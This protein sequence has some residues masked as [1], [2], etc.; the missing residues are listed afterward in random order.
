MSKNRKNK[1]QKELKGKGNCD[2]DK[3]EDVKA[4]EQKEKKTGERLQAEMSK[5]SMTYIPWKTLN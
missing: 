5:M 4:V 1:K 3:N 2:S